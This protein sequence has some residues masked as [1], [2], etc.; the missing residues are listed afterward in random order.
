MASIARPDFDPE[1]MAGLAVV[2]GMFPPTVTPDM[3]P[4]L[5][6]A[7]YIGAP[8]EDEL[9]G[10]G[11]A[12]TDYTVPG[13]NG[14]DIE[15]SELRSEQAAG[16]RPGILYMHAGG[17]VLGDR[18]TGTISVLDWVDRL[19]AVVVTVDYRLA[20]EF[21]D[22]YPREDSYAALEWMA[23]ESDRLG[24]RRDR[25]L[26]S[27]TSGGGGIA[28]GIALAARERGGPKLCGQLLACPMLDDRGTTPSTAQ[29]DGVGIWDRISNETG[30]TALLGADYRGPNVSPYAAPA[31]A[32]DFTNLPRAYL[33]VG[34]A[35]IFR[36]EVIEYAAAMWRDGSDA[37]LHVWAG[38]FHV[39]D[40]FAPHAAVSR[41]MIRTRNAWV[42]KVL[43]D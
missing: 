34:S 17:T 8:T 24:V 3:I 32:V 20:P 6:P 26:V 23:K 27:G 22:P 33:K 13:H 43:E 4:H 11:I 19:G 9:R 35:E 5:R 25:I 15:V 7:A 16:L 36:D 41:E 10:R 38:A 40:I 37:E 39:C 28:A 14:Q 1:L 31:R 2:G 21:P 42:S 18:F 30:W 12:R 29:F